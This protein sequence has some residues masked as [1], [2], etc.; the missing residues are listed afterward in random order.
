[1][2]RRRGR[3]LLLPGDE[4]PPAGRAHRHRDGHRPRPGRPAAPGRDGRAARRSTPRRAV[5]RSSA[6]STPRTPAATSCPGP[7]ASRATTSPGGPFVRVDAG[8]ARGPRDPGRLRLDVRE[9][10]RARRGPGAARRRM[11]RALDEFHVEGVPTTIPVHRWI[12]ESKAFRD[13]THTTTWLER[14]LADA[15]LP[16]QVDLAARRRRPAR[17]PCRPTSWSRST[18]AA[19]RCGSSTS[20]ARWRRRPPT[21]H[22]AHHGEHVHGEIHAPMQGTILKVLVEKGQEIRAGEVVCILEAMKMENHIACDARRRGHRPPD[23]RRPG[24]RD[25]SDARGH[26]LID[27]A[28]RGDAQACRCRKLRTAATYRSGSSTKVM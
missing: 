13:G 19:C 26:R 10:D 16:A 2:H 3:R 6:G 11:L 25:R 8:V 23:P 4:H 22:G 20:A 18:G 7:G 24:R 1:M 15:E 21:P 9:A 27:P 28:G 5:T 17:R 12:L 14:A